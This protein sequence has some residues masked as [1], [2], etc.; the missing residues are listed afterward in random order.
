VCAWPDR[1]H[2]STRQGRN[3]SP[4][5]AS[6]HAC[7]QA[8]FSDPRWAKSDGWMDQHFFS[9]LIGACRAVHGAADLRLDGTS[10]PIAV[11]GRTFHL[12]VNERRQ[13][14]LH[15]DERPW[16]LVLPHPQAPVVDRRC[17]NSILR[18]FR[19]LIV[20]IY[21]IPLCRPVRR[22]CVPAH[23]GE[24]A[25]CQGGLFLHLDSFSSFSAF[26]FATLPFFSITSYRS[27][28]FLLHAYHFIKPSFFSLFLLEGIYIF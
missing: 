2:A 23:E 7:V 24:G 10:R 5:R 26:V 1:R 13:D 16:I 15:Y 12:D 11:H 25:Q 18:P 14:F 3:Y 17:F 6:S 27:C 28:R 22:W 8:E 20:L 19:V 21:F 4:C 9:F